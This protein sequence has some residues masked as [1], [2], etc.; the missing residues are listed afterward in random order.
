MN[1]IKNT[2]MN[3]RLQALADA[4]VPADLGPIVRW[5]PLALACS[6]A[7]AA[8]MVQAQTSGKLKVGLML[9]ATGTFASLGVAIENGFRL[10][11]T[12]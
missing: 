10:Y 4:P 12:E 11:V 6:L 8:P 7:L 9:P 3:S 2:A 1:T 5:L